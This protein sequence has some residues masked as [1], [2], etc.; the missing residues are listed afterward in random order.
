MT[1][2]YLTKVVIDVCYRT[3]YLFSSDGEKQIVDCETMDQFME[4]REMVN[5]AKEFDEDVQ[6]VYCDPITTPAG[7]V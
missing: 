6:V 5:L 1:D 2:E 3:F 7:V 4:L